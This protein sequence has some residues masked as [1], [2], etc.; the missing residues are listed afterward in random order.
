MEAEGKTWVGS[1][2]SCFLRVGTQ[3]HTLP[4]GAAAK[5]YGHEEELGYCSFWGRDRIGGHCHT[6]VLVCG[7]TSSL[8]KTSGEAFGFDF[9][10]HT[11][12]LQV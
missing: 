9:S 8:I 11:P 3:N 1:V 6:D 12:H 5:A 2:F 4:T 10:S 7:P